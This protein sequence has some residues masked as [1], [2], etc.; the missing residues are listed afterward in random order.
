MS[1]FGILEARDVI[2][3]IDYLV[4][5][6]DI[7]VRRM[8][9]LGVGMGAYSAVL[10]AHERKNIRALALDS[11]YP[12]IKFY[13]ARHMF[14]DSAFGKSFLTSN[15]SQVSFASNSFVVASTTVRSVRSVP[16]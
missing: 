6:K 14:N 15:V 16:R 5:R 3:A 11:I 2:G 4:T 13:F 9:I 12:D 7:D 10:A 8:G 1:S